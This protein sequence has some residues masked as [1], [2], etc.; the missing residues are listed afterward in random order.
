MEE[1]EADFEDKEDDVCDEAERMEMTQER[2]RGA[3]VP[4]RNSIRSSQCIRMCQEVEDGFLNRRTGSGRSG[5][6]LHSDEG[7]EAH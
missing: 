6:Y 3:G 4:S 1:E 5:E 2:G 7:A